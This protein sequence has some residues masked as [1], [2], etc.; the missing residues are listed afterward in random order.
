MV[1][2]LKI[3]ECLIKEDVSYVN[4]ILANN[5]SNSSKI[6]IFSL[7]FQNVIIICNTPVDNQ[8][9]DVIYWKSEMKKIC[10]DVPV[11]LADKQVGLQTLTTSLAQEIG[12]D[13]Y[14]KYLGD[15]SDGSVD[16]VFETSVRVY[17]M[18]IG[19]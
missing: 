12:A 10:P 15:N 6:V 11:I 18:K 1:N 14:I 7:F 13:M 5:S 9:S 4:Y 17:F 2:Y 3:S 8:N 16:K 19:M